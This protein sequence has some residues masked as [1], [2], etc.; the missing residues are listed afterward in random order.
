MESDE[1]IIKKLLTHLDLGL[2]V[3]GLDPLHDLLTGSLIEVGKGLGVKF[4]HFVGFVF[5]VLLSVNIS[6]SSTG[7]ICESRQVWKIS[8][9]K[10]K[11]KKN[12]SGKKSGLGHIHRATQ[13]AA[14]SYL[15]L[16]WHVKCGP[17]YTHAR[18]PLFFHFLQSFFIY[19][20]E[21][22]IVVVSEE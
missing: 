6:T 7:W 17:K 8:Q 5:L 3:L 1:I 18:K 2:G 14:P 19:L 11:K 16:R 9:K 4:R 10:K 15:N 12:Q 20:Q 22:S 21:R 13:W